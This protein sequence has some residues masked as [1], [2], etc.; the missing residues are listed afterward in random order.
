MEA[1]E[2]AAKQKRGGLLAR[3][4][5]PWA[6]RLA[7]W[8]RQA[9][10]SI[11]YPPPAFIFTADGQT[12]GNR[13]KYVGGRFPLSEISGPSNSFSNRGGFPI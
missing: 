4:R 7:R 13:A 12:E 5:E 9:L 8:S 11:S 10:S 1:N 6:E 2:I 3:A